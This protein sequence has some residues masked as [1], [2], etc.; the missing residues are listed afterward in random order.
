[1]PAPAPQAA[2]PPGPPRS[3]PGCHATSLQLPAISTPLLAHTPLLSRS[4]LLAR[5]QPPPT[6]QLTTFPPASSAPHHH[7][8]PLRLASCA[9]ASRAQTSSSTRC[10]SSPQ[11][12]SSLSRTRRVL[13]LAPAHSTAPGSLQLLAWPRAQPPA[14]PTL[15]QHRVRPSAH[16][17][18]RLTL[19]QLRQPRLAAAHQRS[20][21]APRASPPLLAH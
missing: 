20:S 8:K 17:P 21:L 16:Q 11:T 10:S 2:R 6:D 5:L 1:M 12:A 7:A 3:T 18:R 4:C 13:L 19:A 9:N 14:R 15:R